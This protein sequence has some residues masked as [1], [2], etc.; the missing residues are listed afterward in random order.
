MQVL[1]GLAYV[2]IG[3]IRI[4]DGKRHRRNQRRHKKLAQ[5]CYNPTP[6]LHKLFAVF[7]NCEHYCVGPDCEGRLVMDL[8]PFAVLLGIPIL[9][10]VVWVM[11]DKFMDM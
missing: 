3:I 6:L 8:W 2:F 9:L 5:G 11:I 1:D 10:Y 4:Y 7:S